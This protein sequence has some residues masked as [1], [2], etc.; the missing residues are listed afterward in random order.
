MKLYHENFQTYT[1]LQLHELI[2]NPVLGVLVLSLQLATNYF[3]A[4][5]KHFFIYKYFGMYL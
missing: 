4:N 2:V 3:E 1:K 5:P